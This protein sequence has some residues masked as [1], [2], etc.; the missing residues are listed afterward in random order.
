MFNCTYS[1][2]LFHNVRSGRK[3]YKT[4]GRS[5]SADENSS[6]QD[7]VGA[8]DQC[9][10]GDFDG[11]TCCIDGF[12]CEEMAECYFEVKLTHISFTRT[13]HIHV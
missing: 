4:I 12:Q 7:P 6:C 5:F 9:G 13:I 1:V 10:G 8:W 2:L 3:R 11:S